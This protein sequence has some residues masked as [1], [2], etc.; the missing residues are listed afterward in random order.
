MRTIL[1]FSAG[2]LVVAVASMAAVQFLVATEHRSERVLAGPGATLSLD[3]DINDGLAACEDVDSFVGAGPG[4]QVQFAVCLANPGGGLVVAFN[5]R[6]IYD[7]TVIAIPE[8][9]DAGA[10]L[11]DNPDTNA[12]TTTFSSPDLGSNWD[13]SGGIGAYPVGDD[14]PATGAGNGR[15]FSGGCGSAVGPVTL[16]SGPLGVITTSVLQTSETTVTIVE[17][18]VADDA[19]NEIGSCNPVNEVPM[20]CLGGTVNGNPD[21]D[22]PSGPDDEFRP[23]G[24]NVPG[25]DGTWP[26]SEAASAGCDNDDDN[27]FISDHI[28]EAAISC[29]TGIPT[30]P[31][32]FDS[33]DDH[34]HD[35]W[36]CTHGSNPR[37]P[38][39]KFL[40]SDIGDADG[41]RVPGLWE[42]R[43]YAANAE[44]TDSDGD[45]CH[46][47]VEIASVDG[48][49]SIGD[50]DRLSVARRALNI[51]GPDVDQDWVL[52]ISANGTVGDE[53][54]LFVAR[55]ALLPDW[56]P[57]MC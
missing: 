42:Q 18:S 32:D 20:T 30:L 14:E 10:A 45:G 39:S 11:D 28:E 43:G 9:A 6:I 53:D 17:A 2:A 50:A 56:Q 47:M 23:N 1:R 36:E 41:D 44:S 5:Y 55:A 31:E 8:V 24:P 34:L 25:D 29:G 16:V 38:L 15:A 49:R 13:C 4:S 33:D 51:W 48:N 37:D 26:N 52:D 19:L 57:K 7:D 3:M 12:G 46:D 54:R 21:C 40:G 22:N 27:D 35:G